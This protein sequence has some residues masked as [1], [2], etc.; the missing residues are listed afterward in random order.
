[1]YTAYI[2]KIIITAVSAHIRV[3]SQVFP[4]TRSSQVSSCLRGAL[5]GVTIVLAATNDN[6]NLDRFPQPTLM[7]KHGQ[8]V[9]PTKTTSLETQYSLKDF[10]PGT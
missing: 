9:D 10:L 1:M 2:Y 7:R 8:E 6:I 4:Q 5:N 3:D